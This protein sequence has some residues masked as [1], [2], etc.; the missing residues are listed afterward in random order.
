[1]PRGGNVSEC[2]PGAKARAHTHHLTGLA[3][4]VAAGSPPHVAAGMFQF[5][6]TRRIQSASDYAAIRGAPLHAS[7]RASRRLMSLACTWRSLAAGGGSNAGSIRF[8]VT[9]GKRNARRAVDRVLIKRIV[10]EA[11]RHRAPAFERCAAPAAVRIDVALQLKSPLIDAQ[12]QPL[13]MAQWRRQVRA[14]VDAL[15]QHALT[16]LASRLIDP[17]QTRN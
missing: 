16:E 6:S 9:V 15:L 8:G 7:I 2:E 5:A 4:M 17:K 12:G 13:A 3:A 11:C 14:E 10:R 1:M